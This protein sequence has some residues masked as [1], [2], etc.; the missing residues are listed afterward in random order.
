MSNLI[1]RDTYVIDADTIDIEIE[2]VVSE[3]DADRTSDPV[4]VHSR[5]ITDLPKVS[6]QY[7]PVGNSDDKAVIT[8]YLEPTGK[9]KYEYNKSVDRMFITEYTPADMSIYTKDKILTALDNAIKAQ[10]Q[11]DDY[12]SKSSMDSYKIQ[13]HITALIDEIKE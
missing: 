10:I 11:T 2:S 9:L 5:T 12:R 1:S 3:L 7:W 6:C 8:V 4:R 13:K